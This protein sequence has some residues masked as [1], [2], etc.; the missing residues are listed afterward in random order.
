MKEGAESVDV[1]SIAP[2]SKPY[3]QNGISC[4]KGD[5][6]A[7]YKGDLISVGKDIKSTISQAIKKVPG[8]DSKD[9]CIIASGKNATDEMTEELENTIQEILPDVEIS[10][11]PGGQDVHTFMVGF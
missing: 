11:V 8:I 1:I 3:N 9:S 4:E 10:V 6:I 7:L 5:C 2:A